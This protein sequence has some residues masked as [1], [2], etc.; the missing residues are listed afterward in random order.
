MRYVDDLKRYGFVTRRQIF[1]AWFKVPQIRFLIVFRKAVTYRRFSFRWLFFSIL[2]KH[3]SLKIGYQIPIGT[4][5]GKG[6][7]LGHRGSIVINPESVIGENCNIA[8]G[9]TIGQTNRGR[10]Q[11]APVIGS[12]VWIGANA[13]IVGKI[14]IGNNVLIAP[15]SYVNM[16]VPDNSIVLG[17]PAQ[18]IPKENATEGYINNVV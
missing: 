9:V 3:Y 16:D 1:F 12:K 2:L 15:N 6:L 4:K 8:Q 13:V 18:I 11:G 17:N 7:Y 5:I 10:L 14:Y